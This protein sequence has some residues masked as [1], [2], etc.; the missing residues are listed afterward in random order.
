MN[1]YK[2]LSVRLDF[3]SVREM[4]R[5]VSYSPIMTLLQQKSTERILRKD[6]F[7]DLQRSNPPDLEWCPSEKVRKEFYGKNLILL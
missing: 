4:V 5:K 3:Y 1:D 6:D 7:I 2:N